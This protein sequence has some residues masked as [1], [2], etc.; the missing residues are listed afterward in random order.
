MD[1]YS[2]ISTLITLSL[3]IRDIGRMVKGGDEADSDEEDSET[4]GV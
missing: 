2:T 4:E 3:W 1:S